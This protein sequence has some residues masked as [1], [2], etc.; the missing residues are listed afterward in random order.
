MIELWH[1]GQYLEQRDWSVSVRPCDHIA[2]LKAGF[3]NIIM[4]LIV[5]V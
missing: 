5:Y 3:E 4:G 1:L 2:L